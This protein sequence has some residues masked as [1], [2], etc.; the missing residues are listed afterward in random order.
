MPISKFEFQFKIST[1]VWLC[2]YMEQLFKCEDSLLYGPISDLI[3]S[4][5]DR[6]DLSRY[7]H[8]LMHTEGKGYCLARRC[9]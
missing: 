8:A 4:V 7:L 2:R 1:R 6:H 5:K 9:N 3:S